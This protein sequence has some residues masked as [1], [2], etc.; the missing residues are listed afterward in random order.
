MTAQF[1]EEYILSRTNYLEQ[2]D[3]FSLEQRIFSFIQKNLN[4]N[5][6]NTLPQIET[7]EQNGLLNNESDDAIINLP[8]LPDQNRT[9]RTNSTILSHNQTSIFVLENH[10]TTQNTPKKYKSKHYDN[11]R[12][13]CVTMEMNKL[14]EILNQNCKDCNLGNKLKH[15]NIGKQFR[16][17]V[18][19]HEKFVKAKIY[20]ILCHKKPDNINTII[21][22]THEKKNEFFWYVSNCSFEQVHKIFTNDKSNN[23]IALDERESENNNILISKGFNYEKCIS[24]KIEKMKIRNKKSQEEIEEKEK[25]LIKYSLNL[26]KDI[27]GEGELTSRPNRYSQESKV[28]DYDTIEEI[29]RFA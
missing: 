6:E 1:N 4:Q 3:S 20:N 21:R 7:S 5:S 15:P 22:M 28:I 10:E 17:S 25:N 14:T 11:I 8:Q 12:A 16:G 29:E 19:T 26:I 23:I 24:E 27:N 9:Q 18:K 13:E 2:E